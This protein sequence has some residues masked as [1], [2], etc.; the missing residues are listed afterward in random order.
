MNKELI[1]LNSKDQQFKTTL[2]KARKQLVISK[3][4]WYNDLNS[5]ILIIKKFQKINQ[6]NKIILSK[7]SKHQVCVTTSSEGCLRLQIE[8]MLVLTRDV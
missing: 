7:H 2:I 1:K 4:S 8:L 3:Y 5:S 6:V